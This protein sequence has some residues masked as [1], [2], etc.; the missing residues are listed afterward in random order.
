MGFDPGAPDKSCLSASAI[1]SFLSSSLQSLCFCTKGLRPREQ[2]AM[3]GDLNKE[4]SRPACREK[5]CRKGLTG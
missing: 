5:K 4:P 1:P 2:K 3:V